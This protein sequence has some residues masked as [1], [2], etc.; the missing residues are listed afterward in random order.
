MERRL[1]KAAAMTEG[2]QM[3]RGVGTCLH[4]EGRRTLKLGFH[5]TNSSLARSRFEISPVIF[6]PFLTTRFFVF[7]FDIFHLFS[8]SCYTPSLRI[9]PRFVLLFS[10]FGSYFI[11]VIF[12]RPMLITE[13]FYRILFCEL[14]SSDITYM[15][16]I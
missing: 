11:V 6:F 15:K 4:A 5:G 7:L 8:I 16:L 12:Y 9:S 3:Y 10:S 13:I 14:E 1:I 2:I